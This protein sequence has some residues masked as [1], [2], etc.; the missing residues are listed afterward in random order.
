[1]AS[2]GRNSAL[3]VNGERVPDELSASGLDEASEQRHICVREGVRQVDGI[4][5][6]DA[7]A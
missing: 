7:A 1:M 5:Y 3:R 6:A 2:T 4:A